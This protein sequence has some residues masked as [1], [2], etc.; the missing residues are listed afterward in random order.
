MYVTVFS[1]EIPTGIFDIPA[2]YIKIGQE[3]LFEFKFIR[4]Y[5]DLSIY[6]IILMY[7]S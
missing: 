2:D 4:I 1:K 3:A 7:K 6:G 5:P